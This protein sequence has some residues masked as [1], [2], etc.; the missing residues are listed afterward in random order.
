MT[1]YFQ[2]MITVKLEIV[3]FSETFHA[4]PIWGINA[5]DT[6]FS[7]GSAMT[8]WLVYIPPMPLMTP[9][10]PPNLPF[11]WA[12]WLKVAW[13]SAQS[14]VALH[15]LWLFDI[16]MGNGPFIDGLPLKMAIFNSYVKWPQVPLFSLTSYSTLFFLISSLV[17][18]PSNS[19]GFNTNNTP[20]LEDLVVLILTNA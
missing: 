16:A 3:Y 5:C 6:F 18:L 7:G 20:Y 11:S 12:D 2:T 15:T 13:L 1:I 17:S 19:S 9:P 4:N 10:L 8:L 14:F